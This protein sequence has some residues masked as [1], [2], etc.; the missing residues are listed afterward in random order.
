MNAMMGVFQYEV[1][2]GLLRVP[3][4]PVLLSKR[5]CRPL[6]LRELFKPCAEC[7]GLRHGGG[8]ELRR[9]AHAS[10][11][12]HVGAGVAG[13]DAQDVIEGLYAAR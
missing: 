8:L 4:E 9:A 3:C 1:N 10:D 7:E 2:A 5:Q 13:A 6:L 11:A 12:Q